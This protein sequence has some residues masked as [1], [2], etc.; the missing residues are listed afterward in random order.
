MWTYP[1]HLS[2]GT[3]KVDKVNVGHVLPV[4][5]CDCL[6][7]RRNIRGTNHALVPQLSFLKFIKQNKIH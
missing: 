2:T 6:V 7:F 3:H 4:A 5:Y 1:G